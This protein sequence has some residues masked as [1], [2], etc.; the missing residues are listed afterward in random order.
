MS[1]R[2][3]IVFMEAIARSQNAR[4]SAKRRLAVEQ[5]VDGEDECDH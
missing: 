2:R 3:G 1:M 4:R 5:I